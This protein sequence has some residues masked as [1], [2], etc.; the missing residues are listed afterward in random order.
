MQPCVSL[1]G[2]G[3]LQLRDGTIPVR[4]YLKCMEMTRDI[5]THISQFTTAG[6]FAAPFQVEA[7][8]FAMLGQEQIEA[9]FA[10][11]L[12]VTDHTEWEGLWITDTR[13]LHVRATADVENWSLTSPVSDPKESI[14]ATVRR[15]ADIDRAAV[16]RLWT[17]SMNVSVA[18]AEAVFSD[19]FVFE[20]APEKW[21]LDMELAHG[22]WDG[23]AARIA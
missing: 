6:V 10:R 11:V 21:R 17:S 20:F 14:T 18:N 4:R 1:I 8:I 3:V 16:T 19:G 12:A 13:V 2:F 15:I 7:A 23:L 5:K 9:G 22:L